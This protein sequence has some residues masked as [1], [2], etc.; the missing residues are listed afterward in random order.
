MRG[1]FDPCLVELL[2]HEGGFVNHPRDPGGMTNLGVTK[3]TYEAWVGHPVGESVMRKLTISH[4][5]ALYLVRYWGAVKGDDLPKGLDLCVFDFAVNAG[6]KRAAKYLQLMVGAKRD[7]VIGPNTIKQ[8]QQY[9]LTH[10]VP[11]AVDRYQSMREGYYRKLPTFG[12]FG[13]GWLRRVS[14]VTSCA[15][16]MAKG[17]K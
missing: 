11:Q 5:R 8:I 12:T 13:R 1:N 16:R 7:G 6:P 15:R 4:V 14:E 2:K 9:T 3:A 17:T 10:G